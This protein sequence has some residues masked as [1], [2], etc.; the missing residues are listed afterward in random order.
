MKTT[1]A[2]DNKTKNRT[3]CA[4]SYSLND[5]KLLRKEKTLVTVLKKK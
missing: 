2:E 4:N 1:E 5:V 3:L